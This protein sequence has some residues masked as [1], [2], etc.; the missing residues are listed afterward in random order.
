MTKFLECN[1]I[2]TVS[3]LTRARDFYVNVIGFSIDFESDD[4]IGL[5]KDEVL[6]LLISGSSENARQPVGS[7]NVSF[8]TDEVDSLYDGCVAANANILVKPWNRPYGQR[9]FAVKDPD[10]NVL[11]FG[12]AVSS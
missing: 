7:S 10:G 11:S 12:C 5:V 4:V 9:D 1:P 8:L 2:I 6:I 3:E